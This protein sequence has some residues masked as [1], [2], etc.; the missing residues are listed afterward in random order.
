[1]CMHVRQVPR[2]GGAEVIQSRKVS[3]V[4]DVD[5]VWDGNL[6]APEAQGHAQCDHIGLIGKDRGSKFV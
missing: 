2:Q 3:Y 1:M 5:H 4:V 6:R